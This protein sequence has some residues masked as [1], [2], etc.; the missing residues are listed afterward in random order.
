MTSPKRHLRYRTA[1]AGVLVIAGS[2]AC[3]TTVTIPAPPDASPASPALEGRRLNTVILG[4]SFAAGRGNGL[5]S[6]IVPRSCTQSSESWGE[7]L[8]RKLHETDHVTGALTN[9]SC[10]GATTY[11]VLY[12][13]VPAVKS[14]TDLVLLQ[15]GGNDI[16][17]DQVL[18]NC[19]LGCNPSTELQR[20]L[21]LL[22]GVYRRINEI[23]TTVHNVAPQAKIL[24][25]DYPDLVGDPTNWNGFKCLNFLTADMATAL[26]SIVSSGAR[27]YASF[28]RQFNI[29]YVSQQAAVRGHNWCDTSDTW[30]TGLTHY[31]RDGTKRDL[32]SIY[33]FHPLDTAHQAI[34]TSAR[35]EL[36]RAYG[37]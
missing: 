1:L 9:V 29:L 17:V 31:E 15:I 12:R 14:D 36:I 18:Q 35:Q 5:Y 16:G 34:A 30:I 23:I 13:Q 21:R 2:A 11:D 28:A 4:D 37:G 19:L 6:T 10:T 27:M 25:T 24:V 32:G 3:T 22:P 8:V 26:R 33:A 7:K 20:A